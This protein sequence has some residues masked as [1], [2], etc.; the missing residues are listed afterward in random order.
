MQGTAKATVGTD[1]F[2]TFALV[3]RSLRDKLKVPIKAT[4]LHL[5]LPVTQLFFSHT[6]ALW[7]CWNIV[8]HSFLLSPPWR[9]S[10]TF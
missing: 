6:F 4:G 10:Q 1:G 8:V 3:V 5:L 2:S 9:P 7:E